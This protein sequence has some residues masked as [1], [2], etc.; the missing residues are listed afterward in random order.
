M[1]RI[2]ELRAERNWT[3]EQLAERMNA[4]ADAADG[5]GEDERVS[6]GSISRIENGKRWLTPERLALLAEAFQVQPHE[7]FKSWER[8][9]PEL[10]RLESLLRE[11]P[12]DAVEGLFALAHA[13]A[14][15][16][17]SE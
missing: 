10:V 15:R 5:G 3:L 14:N 9:P 16:R 17:P 12:D 11:L 6:A 1:L 4:I 2:R 13:A 8:R 7:L